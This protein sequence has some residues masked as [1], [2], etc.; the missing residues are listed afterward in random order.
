MPP[1]LAPPREHAKMDP[2]E[3]PAAHAGVTTDWR[4]VLR[5]AVVGLAVVVPVTVVRVVADREVTNFDDTGWIYPLFLLI[6]VAY[7]LAGYVAG[8]AAPEAPLTHGCLAGMGTLALWIPVRVVIWAVRGED[9]GLVSGDKAALAPGQ[10]FGALV[11][12]AAV[13]M[14]GGHLGARAAT[15]R[16]TVE[17]RET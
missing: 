16:N 7:G 4:S 3:A 5:A 9:K 17:S 6:V 10:V 11:I 13:G 15:R 2:M 14:L 12:A 8:R 1:D